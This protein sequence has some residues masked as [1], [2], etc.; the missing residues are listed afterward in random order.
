MRVC[1]SGNTNIVPLGLLLTSVEAGEAVTPFMVLLNRLYQEFIISDSGKAFEA[2]AN[3]AG[4]KC[5]LFVACVEEERSEDGNTALVT[6]LRALTSVLYS[7]LV[8]GAAEY[9]ACAIDTANA[10]LRLLA[11][12]TCGRALR[13]CD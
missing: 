1:L 13:R 6:L 8:A 11:I 2:G 12:F 7:S 5:R 9:H 4:Y 10:R 3:T